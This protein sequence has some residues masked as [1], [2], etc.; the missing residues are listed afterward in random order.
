MIKGQ[1]AILE[2]V[3]KRF[4]HFFKIAY[5]KIRKALNKIIQDEIPKEAAALTFVTVLSFVPFLML[6]FFLIPE[7]PGVDIHE[8]IKRLFLNVL[9]PDSAETGIAYISKVLENNMPYNIFNVSLLTVT[10]FT[11]FKFINSS[12]DKV[13]NAKEL[14]TKGILYKIGKFVGMILFGFI[15][16]LVIFSSTTVSF[17]THIFN[18]PIF[19][20]LS[21][22]IVPFILFF[23]VNSFIYFFATSLKIRA[24]S[25]ILGSTLASL[26][27]IIVKLGFDYYI[28]NLTNMEAVWGVV[29][30]I[31]IILFWIYLN[32][33]IILLGVE[34]IAIIDKDE[35]MKVNTKKNL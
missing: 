5:L 16:I 22:I 13:L 11:L 25:L 10:S 29:S 6:I 4:A 17:V 24:K 15:F 26:L 34:F 28:A 12:F 20:N 30:S 33:M 14:V 21:F 35:I 23:L 31:P 32:W 8:L 19:R 18:F 27:W 2:K 9:L 1:I 7:I 3:M